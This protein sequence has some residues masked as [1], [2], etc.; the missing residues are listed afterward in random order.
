MIR[1]S[2]LLAG[3]AIAVLVSG[4]LAA[5]LLLVY[6]SIATSALAAILLA[7]AA[8]LRRGEVFTRT[9]P[10]GADPGAG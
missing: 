9:G 2:A 1:L 3:L 5:S 4:V 7:T 10:A 8:V 6:I